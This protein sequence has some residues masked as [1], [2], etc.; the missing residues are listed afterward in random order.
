MYLGE[1]LQSLVRRMQNH[2]YLAK[3]LF[4]FLPPFLAIFFSRI[5]CFQCPFQYINYLTLKK[6][7]LTNSN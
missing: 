1:Y 5:K 2:T 6:W 4:N 3:P 7:S